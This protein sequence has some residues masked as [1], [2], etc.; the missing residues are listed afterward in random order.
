MRKWTEEEREFVVAHAG[1]MMDAEIAAAL[2]REVRVVAKERRWLCGYKQRPWTPEEEDFLRENWGKTSFDG[3][4]KKLGRSRN[5]LLIRVGR[6]G[7]PP[8]LESGTYVS[9]NQLLLA[10][11]IDSG[12][13][14]IQTSWV[15]KRGFPVHMKRR[16]KSRVRVV[17]LD[18]FWKWAEKN[19]SY[20][21][22]G[23]MEPLALGKEPEWVKEQRSK[24]FLSL[25][26]QRKDPWTPDEDA[27]L[28][29]LLRQHKYGYAELS[30]MLHR[31]A[32]AIQRR[33]SDLGL[34][35][36]PVKA[37]NPTGDNKWTDEK[38]RTLADGIRNGDSYMVI[39]QAVGKSEK[40]VRGK[41]WTTYL[42]ENADKIRAM[43]GDGDWG[44]GAPDPTVKQAIHL[45]NG[46]AEV[47]RNLS[48]L[49]AILRKR[50]NDLGY[51]P[52]WQRFMC[53]NWDDIG[54]CLA[55][56][57]DCDSCT[58]FKRIRPQYCARC[59][60]TFYERK[61]NRFCQD[62]RTARKKRAQRHWCRTNPAK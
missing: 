46:R 6:L 3:L 47:R 21:N 27:K 10:L 35:E 30:E 41:V 55:G 44:N 54:G 2:N 34:K 60:G 50:I 11:G 13:T 14:Y 1:D 20:I 52:Y 36:R 39:A 40:A 22:F 43:L 37:E 38:V 12:Q 26:L 29:R 49:D 33:C 23:K 31:S 19:R 24:D 62:C 48:I 28:I 45:S 32:G 18:E 57:T 7:L 51:D 56:G 4:C 16:G 5:A 61:E 42:T 25:S 15:E 17:Y 8:Y 59:G 53:E 9:M 58:E